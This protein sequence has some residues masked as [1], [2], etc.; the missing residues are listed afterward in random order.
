M[1]K[2]TL[3]F[4][5]INRD[6]F[7][8]I[9]SGKKTVETRAASERYRDIK[10]GDVVVLVCGKDRFSKKVK[11]ARTFKTTGALLKVHSLKKIMPELNSEKEWREELYTYP[12]YKEK[13]RKHGIVALEL[14]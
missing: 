8:D 10:A 5:A 3:K 11:K 7:L 9:K 2:Y 12:N 6:I 14:K 1:D 4:R 13:I